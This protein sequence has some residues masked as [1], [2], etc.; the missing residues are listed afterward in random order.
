MVL[1]S[2]SRT[3]PA[4]SL[5]VFVLLQLLDILTT[6]T[7]LRIGAGEASPF[8]GQL[9]HV[10][11]LAAL[12]IAK[13]YAVLLVTIA[14]RYKK[15]RLVVFLNYYFAVVVTWNLGVIFLAQMR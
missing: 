9:M 13:I 4:P 10:G 5:R 1:E 2:V 7:G 3:M 6:V 12:L 14:L 15:P 8:I 11:P